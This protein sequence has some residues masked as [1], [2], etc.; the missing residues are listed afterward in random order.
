[1]CIDCFHADNALSEIENQD[2]DSSSSGR[3]DPFVYT[4][5]DLNLSV[6]LDPSQPPSRAAVDALPLSHLFEVMFVE[7]KGPNDHLAY[8]Q[9]LWLHVLDQRKYGLKAV[10]CHVKE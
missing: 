3:P 10:V 6:L 4:G 9:L 8:R 1:M 5:E 7:V 2:R